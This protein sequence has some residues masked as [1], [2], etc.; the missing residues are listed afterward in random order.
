MGNL[1]VL[2]GLRLWSKFDV[3]L[4]WHKMY[5]TR[6]IQTESSKMYRSNTYDS[7]RH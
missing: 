5:I 3:V 4:V 7:V 6:C 2:L 1:K